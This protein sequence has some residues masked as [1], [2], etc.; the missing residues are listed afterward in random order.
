MAIVSS[1]EDRARRQYV[2]KP[3]VA[4]ICVQCGETFERRSGNEIKFCSLAC[5]HSYRQANGIDRECI[6][7]G[8]GIS[9]RP[10]RSDRMRFCSR[11]CSFLSQRRNA[12]ANKPAPYTKVYCRLCNDCGHAYITRTWN[13]KHKHDRIRSCPDCGATIGKS[14]QYCSDCWRKHRTASKIKGR[15]RRAALHGRVGK[16]R[17]R[18]I[19]YGVAYEPIN[20]LEIFERDGWACKECGIS[21]PQSLRGKMVPNAPELDHVIPMSRG[22]PHLR[23]NVQCLCRKCNII[24]GASLPKAA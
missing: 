24:K 7:E 1:G 17:Q 23:D 6:C 12:I 11:G 2:P 20:P 21:T 5:N 3:K 15:K 16:H 8:C 22:G 13:G 18:A 4:R 9:F 10:K 14:V 19:R